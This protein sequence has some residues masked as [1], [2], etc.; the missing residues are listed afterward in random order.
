MD[1]HLVWPLPNVWLGYSASTQADLD[2]GVADLLATPAAVRFLSLEPLLGPIDSHV[3]D[4]ELGAKW[5][6]LECGIDWV[7][8]GCESGPH[9]RPMFREWVWSIRDQ[10]V[11]AGVPFFLKQ[12]KVGGKLVKM[13]ELDGCVWSQIPGE[14]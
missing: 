3:R 2:R 12:M 4:D 8:V 6:T 10:C 13:P 11:A 5:N 7:I 14:K 1:P 9:A